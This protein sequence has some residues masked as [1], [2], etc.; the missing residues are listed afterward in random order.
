MLHSRYIQHR[1]PKRFSDLWVT[2]SVQLFSDFFSLPLSLSRVHLFAILLFVF[3]R[4]RRRNLARPH[5]TVT[6]GTKCWISCGWKM[7]NCAYT[8]FSSM[9]DMRD[10]IQHPKWEWMGREGRRTQPIFTA[11][12]TV[13][14]HRNE[15]RN[16]HM[17]NEITS[18]VCLCRCRCRLFSFSAEFYECCWYT[19][20]VLALTIS[21]LLF[22]PLNSIF[23]ACAF[24]H[25]SSIA[26]IK[27]L[28]CQPEV[29]S[30][31]K[32]SQLTRSLFIKSPYC[33]NRHA[34]MRLTM[35]TSVS[36]ART[37]T[38]TWCGCISIY[39]INNH[40][41]SSDWMLSHSARRARCTAMESCVRAHCSLL[42][43][44]IVDTIVREHSWY[45]ALFPFQFR[46]RPYSHVM[47]LDLTARYLLRFSFSNRLTIYT[48][49][50]H[51]RFTTHY[52]FSIFILLK[53]AS[54]PRVEN[55]TCEIDQEPH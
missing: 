38:H 29:L 8:W 27:A 46:A 50:M 2:V 7:V 1:F 23:F 26:A 5:F 16:S 12:S 33:R 24:N 41:S 35:H 53:I 32:L 25:F 10:S 9:I 52:M 31:I 19:H 14:S 48:S 18:C 4:L 17:C 11:K 47:N 40:T 15:S 20:R 42:Y 36:R 21:N 6:F 28:F 54:R 39:L 3:I 30:A 55:K 51:G 44:F 22:L 34:A 13:N 49:P 45:L 37:H 43:Y